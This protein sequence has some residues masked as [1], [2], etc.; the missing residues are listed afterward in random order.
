MQ[1]LPQRRVK[2]RTWLLT[3]QLNH[4]VIK[5]TQLS[6]LAY[7]RVISKEPVIP[8]DDPYRSVLM[9][10]MSKLGYARMPYMGSQLVDSAGV[11][12]IEEWIRSLPPGEGSG[13]MSGPA[14]KDSV[15]AKAMQ[16]ILSDDATAER[17]KEA[18]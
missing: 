9:Y 17:R 8:A 13:P 18:L 16:A 4:A 7:Q 3:N 5:K 6:V 15:E 10:R 2:A 1:T 14:T 11:A 12:L